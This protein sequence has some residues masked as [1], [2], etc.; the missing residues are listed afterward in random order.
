MFPVPRLLLLVVLLLLQLSLKLGSLPNNLC[1]WFRD[2][3]LPVLVKMTQRKG[4]V[5]NKQHLGVAEG[6][7]V[8]CGRFLACFRRGRVVLAIAIRI[9]AITV[10]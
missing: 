10:V 9:K 2:P 3:A 5:H 7:K 1:E 4:Y 8:G 6:R